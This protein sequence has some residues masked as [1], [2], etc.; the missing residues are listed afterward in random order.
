M[1]PLYGRGTGNIGKLFFNRIGEPLTFDPVKDRSRVAHGLIFGP[2]GSGKSATINYM[3]MHEMAI[4]KPRLFII[5]KGDSFGLLGSYFASTG[6]SVNKV[7]ITPKVDISLPPYSNAF[8]ALSQAEE[9]EAS[10]EQALIMTADD[11]FNVSGELIDN[12]DDESRDYLSEMEL[13]T[14]LMITG[15]DAEKE[16]QFELPDKQLVRRALLDAT[17]RQR[18][19]RENYVIPSHV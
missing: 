7:K 8:E 1:L 4:Y 18:D 6:L 15:A 16:K 17:R 9:N 2:T 14:R 11:S 5:E 13:I 12:G 19:K 10:M 3:C